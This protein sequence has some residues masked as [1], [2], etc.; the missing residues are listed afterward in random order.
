VV[1]ILEAI[2]AQ[3][4]HA[5]SHGFRTGTGPIKRCTRCVSSVGRCTS[6]G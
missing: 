5:L 2:F 3:E 6:T 1:M 4:F